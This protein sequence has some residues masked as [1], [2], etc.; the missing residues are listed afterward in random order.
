MVVNSE[1]TT[2]KEIEQKDTEDSETKANKETDHKRNS[3]Y[4]CT[5]TIYKI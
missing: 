2:V 5:T 3:C 4:K 1:V